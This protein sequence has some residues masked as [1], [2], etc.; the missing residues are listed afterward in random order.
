MKIKHLFITALFSLTLL[1]GCAGGTSSG[2]SPISSS[3]SSFKEQ[4]YVLNINDMVLTI[5]ES[6][7]IEA[8]FAPTDYLYELS[9]EILDNNSVISL[10]DNIVTGIGIGTALIKA[11][12]KNI[13]NAMVTFSTDTVFSVSVSGVV[14]D[15][16]SE[17]DLKMLSINGFSFEMDKN[18]I[19]LDYGVYTDMKQAKED[20]SS[21]LTYKISKYATIIDAELVL[22][23]SKYGYVTITVLA[24]NEINYKTYTWN[25]T[26]VY[27]SIW[28]NVPLVNA[29]FEAGSTCTGWDLTNFEHDHPTSN[30]SSIDLT[31]IKSPSTRVF[32]MYGAVTDE[33]QVASLTQEVDAS[34]FKVGDKM[35]LSCVIS[36][37][38]GTRI[39]S[40]KLVCGEQ[41]IEQKDMAT[42]WRAQIITQ[43]FVLTEDDFVDGKI[44]VGLAFI[45]Q[46]ETSTSG[47]W[48][49]LDDFVLRHLNKV[50]PED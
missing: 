37:S 22:D 38:Y 39:K 24:E 5:G 42:N 2:T 19:V 18:E 26:D 34:T 20:L 35:D 14:S 6:R 1:A 47:G 30:A 15:L 16:S 28:E 32:S 45:S 27:I 31:P 21:L 17:C 29:D 48:M 50:F 44:R 7:A 25:I 11:T 49:Y 41:Q 9:Y 3:S 4:E 12:A 43:E 10:K 36:T 13:T 8:I 40:I 33:K 46:D 23:E